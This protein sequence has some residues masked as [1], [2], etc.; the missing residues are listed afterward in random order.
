[1]GEGALAMV[2]S[3]LLD[4]SKWFFPS[5]NH[6]F[7]I[8]DEG[9]PPILPLNSVELWRFQRLRQFFIDSNQPMKL[10]KIVQAPC[11]CYPSGAML[12]VDPQAE[13]M[14]GLPSQRV[15]DDL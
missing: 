8:K 12:C 3:L 9:V 15:D 5:R 6:G 11:Y 7:P 1:M 13:A 10:G 14:G 4:R 2:N